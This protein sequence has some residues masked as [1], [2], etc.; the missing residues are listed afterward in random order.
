MEILNRGS[1]VPLENREKIDQLIYTAREMAT[2][3]SRD[4]GF[5]NKSQTNHQLGIEVWTGSEYVCR[6]H[7]EANIRNLFLGKFLERLREIEKENSLRARTVPAATEPA[8]AAPT[9]RP[10]PAVPVQPTPEPQKVSAPP[11][12]N[13]TQDEYLGV[14]ESDDQPESQTQSYADECVP[15]YD[16]VI[17]ALVEKLDNEQPGTE[18]DHVSEPINSEPEPPK[19]TET[20]DASVKEAVPDPPAAVEQNTPLEATTKVGQTAEVRT[21]EVQ[22]S[23]E[24]TVESA[25][26]EPIVI[27]EKEPYN[28]DGCT[29]TAVVQL[30]PETEGVRKCVVS[31]RTHDFT[32]RVAIVDVTSADVL[33][34]ISGTLGLAFDQYRNELPARAADKMKKEKPS[35][36]KQSKSVS[37]P[38]K[39]AASNA[40]TTASASTTPAETDQSQQGLFAS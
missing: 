8:I 22:A 38:A 14:V 27:A 35:A 11:T 18:A 19:T 40:E 1:F 13:T 26:I 24:P 17:E 36:K 30:F 33:D 28:F 7:E 25:A 6:A 31:V 39:A 12:Q 34:Q 15:G 9:R 4:E 21:A 20:A 10:V 32:P 3:M 16:P 23:V 29:V 2:E 5:Q 37:K